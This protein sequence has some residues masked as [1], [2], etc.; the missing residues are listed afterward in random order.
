V[1]TVRWRAWPEEPAFMVLRRK[2][3]VLPPTTKKG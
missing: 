2:V 3:A 1:L